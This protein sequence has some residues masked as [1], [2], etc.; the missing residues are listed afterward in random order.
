MTEVDIRIV[1]AEIALAVANHFITQTTNVDG[2]APLYG[3]EEFAP[4]VMNVVQR[5]SDL[6]ST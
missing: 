3:G 2:R 6:G 1:R 5:H 4:R